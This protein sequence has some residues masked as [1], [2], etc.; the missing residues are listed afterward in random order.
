MT[1][2]VL[3]SDTAPERRQPNSIAGPRREHLRRIHRMTR[4]QQIALVEEA[5]AARQAD[6]A[7]RPGSQPCEEPRKSPRPRRG[8]AV[9]LLTVGAG[10][11]AAIFSSHPHLERWVAFAMLFPVAIFYLLPSYVAV[12]RDHPHAVTTAVTNVLLG[13]TVVGWVGVLIWSFTSSSSRRS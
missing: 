3:P 7:H 2:S 1:R 13:W 8:Q 12:L 5:R 6:Q 11:L 9:V 10:V 4:E